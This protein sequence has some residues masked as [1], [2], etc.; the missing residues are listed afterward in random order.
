MVIHTSRMERA[1][2]VTLF[3]SRGGESLGEKGLMLSSPSRLWVHLVLEVCKE[4][5]HDHLAEV[6]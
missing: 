6:L 3:W 1:E 5:Q 4:G 2:S